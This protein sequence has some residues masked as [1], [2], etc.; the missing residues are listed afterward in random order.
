MFDFLLTSKFSFI[1]AV[2]WT[3]L[4]IVS[5]TDGE[6]WVGWLQLIIAIHD[7]NEG[8]QTRLIETGYYVKASSLV[9]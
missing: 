4:A 3:F 5:F 6:Y 1:L 9:K 7:L 2:T 8:M